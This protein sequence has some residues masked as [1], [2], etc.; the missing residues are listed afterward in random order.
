MLRRVLG[1]LAVGAVVLAVVGC[2]GDRNP[3]VK[4]TAKN[5]DK[6]ENKTATPE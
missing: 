2:G 1:F 3:T 5:V 6:Q 4:E